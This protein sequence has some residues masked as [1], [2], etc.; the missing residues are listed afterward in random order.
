[1]AFHQSYV[2]Q[3]VSDNLWLHWSVLLPL[4]FHIFW[5]PLKIDNFSAWWIFPCF[6]L[7]AES[8]ETVSL[9]SLYWKQHLAVGTVC[10][11]HITATL[12]T[13][14]TVTSSDGIRPVRKNLFFESLWSWEPVVNL[15]Q[16]FFYFSSWTLFAYTFFGKPLIDLLLTFNS[17]K[18]D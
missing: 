4:C 5:F 6:C 1:M 16:W 10:W 18:Q 9:L 3:L 2:T 8:Y 7:L 15:S 11:R 13:L 17:A 14:W 12:T